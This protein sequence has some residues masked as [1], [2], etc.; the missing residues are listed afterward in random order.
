M[1]EFDKQYLKF[2]QILDTDYENYLV[3]Y[4]CQESAEYKNSKSGNFLSDQQV[5]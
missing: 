1:I 5:F 3:V 4:N 2:N